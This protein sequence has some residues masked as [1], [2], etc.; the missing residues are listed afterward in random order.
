MHDTRPKRYFALR[1][2]L[3]V[4]QRRLFVLMSGTLIAL[5]LTT[6]ALRA[7]VAPRSDGQVFFRPNQ[8]VSNDDLAQ[9]NVPP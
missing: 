9:A 3:P 2:R 7:N 4:E 6:A 5:L 1:T 8:P